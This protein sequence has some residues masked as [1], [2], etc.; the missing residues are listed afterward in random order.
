MKEGENGTKC[1]FMVVR[2]RRLIARS[3]QFNMSSRAQ[4]GRLQRSGSKQDAE[5]H[6]GAAETHTQ[7]DR[8]EIEVDNLS[9]KNI[10]R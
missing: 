1:R 3:A 8:Q 4:A 2:L 6:P 7:A 5:T 10:Y 9:H